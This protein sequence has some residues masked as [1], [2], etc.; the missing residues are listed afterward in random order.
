[1]KTLIV[2]LLSTIVT[3]FASGQIVVCFTTGADQDEASCNHEYCAPN[4]P[5]DISQGIYRIPYEVGVIVSVTNDHI[6]HCPR[7]AID[8]SGDN[9]ASEYNIVASADGWI[10]AISDSHTEQ[11]TCKNGDN[12]DNNYVWIEH[13][14]GEWTKYTHVKFHSASDL[15]DEDDWVT[16][17]TVIGKEGTVGCST[18]DHC[19]FEVAVPV[20]TNT[21]IF[22]AGGG[23]IDEDWADNLVPLFCNVPGYIMQSGESY[24]V[25]DCGGA[26]SGSLPV[27]NV[28]Y[29]AGTFTAFVDDVAMSTSADLKFEGAASGVIQGSS[30]VTLNP[31]F[32]AEFLSTFEARTGDCLDA[33]IYKTQ[34]ELNPGNEIKNSVSIDPNP[35]SNSATIHWFMNEDAGVKISIC[36]MGRQTL[37][38]AV[39]A[40]QMMPGAHQQTIDVSSLPSGIYLV[41]LEMNQ[42]REI[43]KLVIQR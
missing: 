23:W 40:E 20:D 19:H 9:G 17:G 15:H 27:T 31:G 29:G 24:F 6:K 26:C 22:D 1:M 25:I 28:T 41:I 13:P 18:G 39:S 3:T 12:C 33:N 21:L 2:F 11:C 36:D 38:E 35:V 43:Q 16:E 32:Q 14:N 42:S 5:F 10:R 30:S 4:A 8:M 7:G 34:P 37:I